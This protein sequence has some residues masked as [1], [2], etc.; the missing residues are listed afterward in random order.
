[1]RL[2]QTSAS[3]RRKD[4]ILNGGFIGA[5]IGAVGGS[6]LIVAAAGGSDDFPKAMLNVSAVPA[7]GGFAAGALIDALR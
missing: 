3:S 2:S 5:A 4:S 1:M 7:L 6:A